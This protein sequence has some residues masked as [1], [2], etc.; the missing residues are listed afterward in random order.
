MCAM[1]EVTMELAKVEEEAQEF[2][3]MIAKSPNWFYLDFF[4]EVFY[5][6]TV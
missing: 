2:L 4:K 5:L 1:A 3:I 6:I